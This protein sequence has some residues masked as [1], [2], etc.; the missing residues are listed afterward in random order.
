MNSITDANEQLASSALFGFFKVKPTRDGERWTAWGA[1]ERLTAND[2]IREPAEPVHFCSA[3]SEEAAI[4]SLTKEM[5]EAYGK[6]RWWR[7]NCE[8]NKVLNE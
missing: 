4:E 7:Q 5:D 3:E 1:L 2:P 6:R 8:P